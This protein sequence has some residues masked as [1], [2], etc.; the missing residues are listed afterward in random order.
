MKGTAIIITDG[1]FEDIHAKTAHG[2]VRTSNRFDIKGIIASKQAG[3]DAGEVLDGRNR[4]IPIHTS[5]KSY[6]GEVDET[7]KYCVVGVATH[8]GVVTPSVKKS[9]KEALEN[10]MSIICGLHEFAGD[11]PELAE[12]AEQKGLEIKDVRRPKPKSEMKFWSGEIRQ[13]TSVK[14][15]VLGTDC[16]LGKRTTARFLQEE[17]RGRGHAS[18]MIYTGQT[19]W[20]QGSDYGFVFDST[21]NDF[22]S[23][24]IEN[25]M[26]KCFREVNPDFMFI[27]GQ[28]ALRNPMGPCGSEFIISAMPDGIILQHSPIRKVFDGAEVY[29]DAYTIPPIEDEIKLIEMFGGK[30]LAVTLNTMNMPEKDAREF[31]KANSDRLGIPVILPKEDGVEELVPLLEGLIRKS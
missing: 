19:G 21:F 17:M 4:G 8:G 10:G 13:V 30:V 1:D 5:I 16:A 20:M 3:R 29:G 22:V 14:I 31:A 12:L 2:L 18:E 24:E 11:I 9:M 26:V 7:A 23:G 28:S 6:L 15:A 25:A 27:E